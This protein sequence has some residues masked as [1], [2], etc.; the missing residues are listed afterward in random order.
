MTVSNNV[1]RFARHLIDSGH[2]IAVYCEANSECDQPKTQDWAKIREALAA[3]EMS[4]LRIYD[5]DK[6]RIGSALFVADVDPDEQIADYSTKP[7]IDAAYI[8][9][10]G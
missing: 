8:A 3:T 9:A 10:F 7:A 1:R 2:Y 5:A 6:S 4:Y